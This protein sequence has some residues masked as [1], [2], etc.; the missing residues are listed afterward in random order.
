MEKAFAADF[1]QQLQN[2]L[3]C[4]DKDIILVRPKLE[5][6]YADGSRDQWDREWRLWNGLIKTQPMVIG[7]KLNST[8]KYYLSINYH[9]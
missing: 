4:S 1:A 8:Q 7:L 5:I 2:K 9:N 6:S 3:E